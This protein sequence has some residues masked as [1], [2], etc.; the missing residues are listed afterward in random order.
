MNKSVAFMAA[1]ALLS[2]LGILIFALLSWVQRLLLRRWHL[3][4]TG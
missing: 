1:L 4:A 3:G 2:V